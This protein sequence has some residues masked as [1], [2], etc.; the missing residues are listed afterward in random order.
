M[1]TIIIKNGDKKV[2]NI[3][4]NLKEKLAKT[5]S[6]FMGKI[7][8]TVKKRKVVDEKMLA[9]I[10][11]ILLS[12]D[13][14]IEMTDIIL[15][16]FKE[17]LKKDKVTD[18]EI[19]QIYLTDVMRDIL[20][21]ENEETP[22]FFAEPQVKPYVVVFVGV[23]GTGK[24]TTIGKV[25]YKFNQMG[26]KVLIVAGD[27]FRAAA[28]EQIAIWAERAGVPIVRSQPDSD[29]AA[30]IYD[31]VH[32]AL[33]RGY[34]VVLIDTAGRQHT[35]DNL[36]KELSK[37]ERT[38]QKLIPDAPHEVI[39]V[40]DATTGQ[41]AVSQAHNF[42]KAMKL[43]GIALTKYDGTSKGGIIFNLKYNLQLPVKLLGVGEGIEDL[44]P[45][46]AVPFVKAFFEE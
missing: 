28:I 30:I 41:N 44:L 25:A 15:T 35:K 11:E 7:T 3:V 1:S 46:K 20:L 6:N 33:A 23:N 36:M 19:A 2:L 38:I 40:V 34:D 9:E 32:S 12:C 4:K 16:R 22:D 26:K 45:F 17:Q 43:T 18:P 14:G 10:E 24:T 29:P 31:G 5:N 21:A 42:D 39:L 8:E 27:T 13:T 37:I